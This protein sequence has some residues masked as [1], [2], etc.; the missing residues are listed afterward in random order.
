MFHV[1]PK[2]PQRTS[3]ISR[4]GFLAG[5]LAA[6][7]APL[8]IPARLLGKEAPSRI[9]RLGCIGTGRMGSLDF[10][11]AMSEGTKAGARLV[12]LCDVES[13]RLAQAKALA[14]NRH[15]QLYGKDIPF[16]MKL[17]SDYRELLSR[18]DIDGVIIATPDHWHALCAIHAA[19][20]GKGIYVEKPMTYTVREGQAL[21]QAVRSKA[22]VL[23]VG[24]Q[25]RSS[26]Y[27]HRA[28]WLVRNGHIGKLKEIEVVLP[29]D[30]GRAE[31][32]PMPVP[33]TLDY[34]H[35]MGPSA[36]APFTR[37]R[38]YAINGRPGWFQIERYCLGNIAN[39]GAHMFDIAQ[40]GL[41]CDRE[42]GPV[43]IKATGEFPERGLFDVHTRFQG[44]ARYANGV[45][46]RSCS[47]SEAPADSD[48]EKISGVR[49][50]GDNG[51][52]WV[53]RGEL[54]A[55]DPGLLRLAPEGGVELAT[56]RSHM[57][58][59]FQC[60]RSGKDPVSPVETG[61]RTATLCALHHI[62][63]KLGGRTLR[64]DSLR[65][66]IVNDPEA[67]ALL[68]YPYRKAYELPS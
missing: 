37:D 56:S 24:S 62:S 67:S 36:E 10:Q 22:V 54:R 39:W 16:E 30:G 5:I 40:W 34:E 33:S 66:E 4:R 15:A 20:A 53:Q 32:K 38:V 11:Q 57:G 59:F 28:C 25:Q 14:A 27:F 58:N 8:F 43:E 42:G 6:G 52:V 35:W 55:S 1:L 19:E 45:L 68:H 29:L 13:E 41:G 60:L 44:V 64:W 17:H 49:F 18:P 12:A 21:V 51:W 50:T 2:N 23:Q 26:T 46:L 9:L 31:N 48:M 63:M 3:Q 47:A 7:I 65:Q 61:H